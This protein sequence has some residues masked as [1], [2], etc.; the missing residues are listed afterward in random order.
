MSELPT[1]SDSVSCAEGVRALAEEQ[2]SLAKVASA[3]R[4]LPKLL[5][6]SDLVAALKKL[7]KLET[8]LAALGVAS[9][10][11]LALVQ[12]ARREIELRRQHLR[13]RLSTEL[14]GECQSRG[15]SLRVV[16]REEP[17][18]VRIAP[19]SVVIDREKGRAELR[20][21]K[22]PLAVCAAD[23]KA[24]LEAREEALAELQ[25]GFD[26]AVFFT[27]CQRAWRA[28]KS[29]G[30]PDAAERVE[31]LQFLPQLALQ[32]QSDS[33]RG[34]PSTKNY[35]E[36]TRA[37]FAFDVLQLQRAGKLV[38]GGQRL[39]FGVATGTSASNRNRSVWLE[40]EQGEGEF[41]LT[42]YFTAAE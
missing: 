36:Y 24:I 8:K 19:L 16:S 6:S 30:G 27:A 26:P 13:E 5:E 7:A 25:K 11:G 31:L 20:F 1:E 21:A 42:V 18:E 39:N 23:A 40:N 41:K 35:R 28:A 3:L 17:V 29:L 15:I 37:R 38:Q 22:E 34:R 4:P 2:R 33:F 9:S 32:M 12:A 14:I 10:R